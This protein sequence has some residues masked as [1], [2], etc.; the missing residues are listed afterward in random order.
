MHLALAEDLLRG[1]D[2]PSTVKHLL[3]E[4]R[5]A[6]LLGHTAPDVKTVS[7]Q[8]R[9]ESHFY[10]IPRTSQ[11]PAYQALFTAYPGLLEAHQLPPAQAV[12]IAGY[13]AHLLLDEIWLD[14]IFQRYFLQEWGSLRERLFLHNVLRTWTD[15]RDQRRLK[16]SIA[17]VLED[18][19]PQG[20]LPFVADE[21]LRTW[22]DWLIEQLS[23]NQLMQTAEV[24]AQRM[25]LP[26]AAIKSVVK[27]PQQMEERIFSRIPRSALEAVQSEGYERS[28]AL[29]TAYIRSDIATER[30]ILA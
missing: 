1:D 13:I 16:D 25:D 5:G 14:H 4:H 29:I 22:R 21:H 28:A 12:F 7:G 2:L 23:A 11:D 24:F 8:C 20:W 9:E 18:T 3:M 10:T 6:F 27:S 30:T 17:L 15:Y 26:A 19:S